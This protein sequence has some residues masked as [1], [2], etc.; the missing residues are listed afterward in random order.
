MTD[1]QETISEKEHETD[2][3]MMDEKEMSKMEMI[4]VMKDMETEMKE[5]DKEM[6]SE[7]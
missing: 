3:G 5:M 2:E 7:R 6:V 4:K 1:D